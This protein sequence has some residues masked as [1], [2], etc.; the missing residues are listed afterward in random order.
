MSNSTPRPECAKIDGMTVAIRNWCH[1]HP[2]PGG[3]ATGQALAEAPDPVE[4]LMNDPG[5]DWPQNAETP[6]APQPLN[7]LDEQ[8][9]DAILDNL[10]VTH[11]TGVNSGLK[12]AKQAIHRLITAARVEELE[13]FKKEWNVAWWA[14]VN[15]Q[16]SAREMEAD[17][18]SRLAKLKEAK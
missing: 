4:K 9:E 17:I 6:A 15:S 8:I 12:E 1:T 18:E 3:H 14:K 11:P 16:L 13:R 7:N 2:A 10:G 5:I